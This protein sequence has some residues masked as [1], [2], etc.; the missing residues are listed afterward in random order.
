MDPRLRGDNKKDE[1]STTCHPREGGDPFR[2]KKKII[3]EIS[4]LQKPQK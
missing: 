3:Y 1:I 2:R 4:N